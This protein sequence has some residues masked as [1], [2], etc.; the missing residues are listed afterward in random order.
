MTAVKK[1]MNK[2]DPAYKKEVYAVVLMTGVLFMLKA[3]WAVLISS[4]PLIIDELGYAFNADTLFSLR[5]FSFSHFPQYPLAHYPPS[6][7]LAIAPAFFF[8]QRYEAML[9]LNAFWSSLLVPATWFLARSV[10]IRQAWLA[11]VLAAFLPM[12]VIYPNSLLSE[13]LFVPLF[14]LAVALALR[15]DRQRPIEALAFGFILGIT[16]LSKYLFLPA[17]PLLFGTWLYSRSAGKQVGPA[18]SVPQR[19]TP[20]LLA[21]LAYGVVI[22]LWLTY[23]LTSGFR[24]GELFG[25][26]IAGIG[27]KARAVIS[28][29]ALFMWATVYT[30][31]VILAWLPVWGI[32][33]IWASQ[34]SEKPWRPKL[35]LRHFRFPILLLLLVGGYWLLAVK[36][37]FGAAYNY[38][39]PKRLIGR[40]L[41][42]LSPL[43]L[44]AG[45]WALEKLAE[46]RSLFRTKRALTSLGVLI[47]AASAA[48]WVLFHNGI[49]S[50]TDTFARRSPTNMVDALALVSPQVFLLAI[51]AVVSVAAML[52]VRG[53][54]IRS[55]ELAV[56]LAAFMLV[57]LAADAGRVYEKQDALHVREVAAA[58]TMLDKKGGAPR[59][60]DEC[61]VLQ[62]TIFGERMLFWGVKQV[63]LSE[64]AVPYAKGVRSFPA[65][66]SP[67]LLLTQVRLD[68]KPLREYLVNDQLFYV[69]RVDGAEPRVLQ[70]GPIGFGSKSG[71]PGMP[72]RR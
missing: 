59:V 17:L 64:E 54:A 5:K 46:G 71:E 22:G 41:M 39:E 32:I 55:V 53:N 72:L 60:Y 62:Q 37:S 19:W 35:E 49:W 69:Y 66:S 51:V 10:G 20:A 13:N 7:P 30:A 47:S 42:H 45:V 26:G 24:W 27:A 21:V 36:H 4:G 25:L 9:I 16:H 31:Y 68:M 34:L 8:K 1:I 63:S 12:H 50:F 44:V 65:R 29:N 38:P 67:T 2:H 58:I 61:G 48:W 11:A 14:V 28:A 18:E 56:P 52:R 33:A 70:P 43:M 15:G 40:Y 3:I 57:S 6:Y 23:G